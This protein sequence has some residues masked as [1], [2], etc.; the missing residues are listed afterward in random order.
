MTPTSTS[1]MNRATAL[2]DRK[3]WSGLLAFVLVFLSMPLGHALMASIEYIW[4]DG[5]TYAAAIAVG[6]VGFALLA[7]TR[8][9]QSRET[10]ATLAGFLAAILIWTGWVEFAF[11]HTSNE[12]SIPDLMHKGKIATKAEYLLMPSSI[13]L[14]AAGLIFFLFKRDTRCGFFRFGQKVMRLP[15]APSPSNQDPAATTFIETIFLIWC[16][17]LVLLVLY[18][19]KLVGDRHWMTAGFGL[20]CFVWWLYLFGRLLRHAR[21][22]AAIRYAIPTVVI[23]WNC[24]EILGRW[25]LLHEIWIEPY[26]YVKEMIFLALAFVLS[27]VL[28]VMWSRRDKPDRADSRHPLGRPR[29]FP[30]V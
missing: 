4:S 13:G 23:F 29:A 30:D 17:Y 22:S 2:L 7:L 20:F 16:F 26:H 19:P 10:V 9:A 12:L 25:D 18:N 11:V 28:V 24:V 1:N 5:H 21:L 14:L 27:I 8:Y 15:P 3:P 6:A